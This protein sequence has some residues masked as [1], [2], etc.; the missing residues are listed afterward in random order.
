MRDRNER[1]RKARV[2]VDTTHL[3]TMTS[4]TEFVLGLSSRG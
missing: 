2:S 3:V 1:T 4:A